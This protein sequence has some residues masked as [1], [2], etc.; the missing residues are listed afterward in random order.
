MKPKICVSILPK[1]AAEA[2]KQIDKANAMNAE[3]IEIRLDCFKDHNQIAEVATHGK[4]TKIATCKL[5]SDHGQFSGNETEQRQMLFSAA[6]NG[7]KYV[8]V[9]LHHPKL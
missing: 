9:D 1:T 2:M 4:T 7:F 5:H 8:D 3:L 6:R